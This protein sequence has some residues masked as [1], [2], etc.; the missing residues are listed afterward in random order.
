MKPVLIVVVGDA[1]GNHKLAGMFNNF[2]NTYRANHSCNCP[3]IH[4][5]DPEYACRFVNQSDVDI[6]SDMGDITT[7]NR[8]SYHRV[9]NA[10][11]DIDL[12]N[13]EAGVDAMMPS[14]ILHQMFLG[15]MEYVPQQ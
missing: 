11:C 12:A 3:L 9:R 10:F 15:V 1:V 14:E 13:H 4:T 8:L 7:L 5:D 6:L 2:S